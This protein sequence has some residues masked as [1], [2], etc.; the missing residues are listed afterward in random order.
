MALGLPTNILAGRA[1]GFPAIT[2]EFT[3]PAGTTMLL[4]LGSYNNV[5]DYDPLTIDDEQG[6]DWQQ[7]VSGYFSNS[8]SPRVRVQVWKAVSS[9]GANRI[10]VDRGVGEPANFGIQIVGIT[11]AQ[12]DFSNAAAAIH[13]AGDPTV[14]LPSAPHADSTVIGFHCGFGSGSASPPSGYVKLYEFDIKT[15]GISSHPLQTVYDTESAAQS[16][17]W[18]TGNLSSVSALVEVK[19]LAPAAN[20]FSGFS[21]FS[22]GSSGQLGRTRGVGGAADMAF[23]SAGKLSTVTAMSGQAAMSF[24]SSG[25]LTVGQYSDESFT[26]DSFG[27]LDVKLRTRWNEIQPAED[28]WTRLYG[29][30]R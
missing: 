14:V 2:A 19:E 4:A 10:T 25:K 15:T 11:G 7:V 13:Q 23:A 30:G 21:S 9:G 1:S 26:F 20:E 6:L 22:F 12:S 27:S 8:G 18:S 29:T 28:E 24:D 5:F 16:A 17:T 3:V